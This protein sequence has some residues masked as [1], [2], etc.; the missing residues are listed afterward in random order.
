MTPARDSTVP[1]ALGDDLRAAFDPRSIAIVG[2]SDNADKLGGR[3]LQFLQRFGFRGGIYPINPT[4]AEV[5]GV[6]AYPAF[7]ALPEVAE[8]VV[9]AVPGDQAVQAVEQCGRHGSR[10]AV[11]LSAGFGETDDA[12]RAQERRMV[13]I[14]RRSGL[15]LIG[16]N[17]QGIAN[18]A[19]GAIGNFSTMFVETD[20]VD[21]P[22]AIVTQSGGSFAVP[23]GLL[24]G[25]GVGVRYA[26][27]IGNQCDVTVSELAIAAAR[28]P[29][30]KLLLLYME[31]IPDANHLAAV[32]AIA[33]ERRLPVLVVKSGRTAAGQRASMSHTGSLA[34]E[35]R[36]VDA[37]LEYHGLKR[38]NDLGDLAKAAELYLQGWRPEGRRLVVISNSGT[39]CVLTAD[40]ATG[41]GLPINELTPETRAALGKVLPSFASTVNPVDITAALLSNSRLFGDILPIIA[42][43]PGA[44]IFL[45][46]VPVSGRGYDLEAFARDAAAF[47]KSTGKP[48]V[49]AV[50]QP[51]VAERFKQAGLPVF[52]LESQ[53][54]AALDQFVGL[55]EA[56]ENACEAR[57]LSPA[58]LVEK[59]PG[60]GTELVLNEADALALAGKHG[61]PVVPHRLCVSADQVAAAAVEFGGRVAV[62][63]CTNA[64]THKSDVGLVCLNVQGDAAARAAWDEVTAAAEKQSIRLDGV[65]VARMVS[66]RREFIVGAHRDPTF[67]P[68]LTVGDGGKYVEHLPDVQVLMGGSTQAEIRRAVQRLRVAPILAGVRGE[69][70]MDVDALVTLVA[71]VGRLMVDEPD[72]VSLDL[73]PVLVGALGEGCMALDGVVVKRTAT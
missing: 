48:V 32:G 13:E 7:D 50:P 67:G 69:P 54:V 28:D 37:F 29:Q 12:G 33:R 9:I 40:A 34:T 8:L 5:Q 4:R 27:A 63:G 15:R 71:S 61:V 18:F 3:V 16:P 21:G 51:K 64:V 1:D 24:R 68:V 58:V 70:P 14:A 66:G 49:M 41:V 23:F 43:D 17:S 31:G 2:A 65:L 52:T 30:I 46:S 59:M 26:N 62:K 47:V 55:H 10:V 20:P 35:D 25:Q 72:V 53:A 38:V 57:A 73:N 60:G 11:I 56:L 19:N 6:K 39:A 45:I 22:V 42:K 36:V 44:D